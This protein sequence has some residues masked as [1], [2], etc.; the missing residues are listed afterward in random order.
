M[1]AEYQEAK[2]SKVRKNSEIQLQQEAAHIIEMS[3]FGKHEGE[4]EFQAAGE[5]QDQEQ[6]AAEKKNRDKRKG[7]KDRKEEKRRKGYEIRKIL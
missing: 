4:E 3:S 7:W 6:K 1:E 2:E 5:D